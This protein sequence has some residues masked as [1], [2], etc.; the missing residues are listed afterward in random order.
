MRR[1]WLTVARESKNLSRMQ[2][3]E[4]CEVSVSSID[5]YE[6]GHRRPSPEVAKVIGSELGFAW[7][8]FYED[9]QSTRI[10]K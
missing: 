1:E 2:L 5:L 4:R 10:A 7:T 8:S 6:S 3:A 9:E